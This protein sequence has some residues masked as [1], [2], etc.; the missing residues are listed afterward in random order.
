MSAF[1]Q[2]AQI[3]Q[4]LQQLLNGQQELRGQVGELQNQRGFPILVWCRSSTYSLTRQQC[5]PMMLYNTSAVDFAPLRYPAGIPI[6]N[7]PAT[8]HEFKTFMEPQLQVAAEVLGLP[9]LPGNAL[10]DQRRAQI[11]E[12]L[13][14]LY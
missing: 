3:I 9:A 2:G 13:G 1:N 6:N 5:L 10:V 12:Y 11:A 7:L 14:I 4:M 8:F